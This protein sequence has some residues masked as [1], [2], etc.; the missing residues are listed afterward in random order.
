MQKSRLEKRL[1]LDGAA[2]L[3][4]PKIH[5]VSSLGLEFNS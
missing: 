5:R 3:A 2:M 1:F 4:Q